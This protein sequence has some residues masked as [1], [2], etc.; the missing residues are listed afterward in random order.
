MDIAERELEN[1]EQQLENS[2]AVEEVLKTKF[3]NEALYNWMVGRLSEIYFQAWDLTYAAAKRAERAFRFERGE[4]H[5]TFISAGAWDNLKAGLLAGDRLNHDLRRLEAAYLD[6]ARRDF[7]LT[8]HVSLLEIAPDQLEA[9]KHT[10]TCTF[11]LPESLF[12]RDYPG[13]Y[14]RRIK[15][16]AVTIPC[17]T[18]PYSGVRG[19]L[20]LLQS[21]IR[22]STL[23]ND[24]PPPKYVEDT[25]APDPRFSYDFAATQSIALS[26]GQNDS[27]LFE[28]N[29]RDERY[30]PFEGAGAISRFRLELSRR[31]NDFDVDSISDVILHLRYTARDGGELLAKRAAAALPPTP[32]HGVRLFSARNELPDA[33]YEFLHE[34]TYNGNNGIHKLVIPLAADQFPMRATIGQALRILRV[35]MLLQVRTGVA[36]A[37]GADTKFQVKRPQQSASTAAPLNPWPGELADAVL[38]GDYQVP[39]NPT[40]GA[41]DWEFTVLI[42]APSDGITHTVDGK[43]VLD[44]AKLVDLVVLLQY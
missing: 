11:D 22:V 4:D 25:S 16:V 13:H 10:G 20:T 14:Q 37:G 31:Y 30:L 19:R 18:G 43:K 7:E 42:G 9:L 2:Q 12:D 24:P 32:S 15:T 35:R 44:S 3:T 38:V 33:W 6:E 36:Y 40:A 39:A 34:P 29:L 5:P 21:R 41:G 26:S 27:G 28:T 1:H 8:R 23:A 17:T